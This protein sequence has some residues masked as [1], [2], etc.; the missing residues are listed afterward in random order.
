MLYFQV[1]H[2]RYLKMS[3]SRTLGI[4]SWSR[5]DPRQLLYSIPEIQTWSPH[6][7]K[8]PF[9]IRTRRLDIKRLERKPQED[10][11]V[12]HVILS[13]AIKD[14]QLKLTQLERSYY[15]PGKTAHDELKKWA[16][17][18]KS[19]MKAAGVSN[20]VAAAKVEE[21]V[22]QGLDPK[23]KFRVDVYDLNRVKE[24]YT[25]CRGNNPVKFTDILIELKAILKY[26][27]KYCLSFYDPASLIPLE[28]AQHYE[29]KRSEWIQG[30]REILKTIDILPHK[31]KTS[32]LW[33]SEF[34]SYG[35]ELARQG[36]CSSAPFLVIFPECC[37]IIRNTCT[38]MAS[39]VNA[40]S[41]YA[42]FISNDITDLEQKK[43]EDLRSMQNFQQKYHQLV[44]KLRQTQTECDKL[45]AE[46]DKLKERE[47][48]MIVEE[49]LLNS[50]S[51][52]MQ[53]EIERKEYHREDL[54]RNAAEMHPDIL[55]ERYSQLAEALRDIKRD[56]PFVQRKLFNVRYK[57]SW[58]EEK[59]EQLRLDNRRLAQLRKEMEQTDQTREEKELECDITCKVSRPI[60]LNQ[61][62]ER[63]S[64]VDQFI[65]TN[66]D[67]F[68]MGD[69]ITPVHRQP[70]WLPLVDGNV[71]VITSWWS[72]TVCAGHHD[73]SKKYQ[74][75]SVPVSAVGTSDLPIQD[76]PCS[77]GEDIPWTACASKQ[78]PA[79]WQERRGRWVFL[80][81]C[82]T[83]MKAKSPM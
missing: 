9:F 29:K 49:E 82:F 41:T 73:S 50:Q 46:L 26:L 44:F 37:E 38:A 65:M 76:L 33:L 3:T 48:E 10:L 8:M 60:G 13:G 59:R 43:E 16:P 1:M 36:E 30:I 14:T 5:Q 57:L 70:Y 20:L 75:S 81:Q 17:S 27:E 69:V 4:I 80:L 22:K 66:A 2:N 32:E 23:C 24:C 61:V 12:I 74:F 56:L 62:M 19:V 15:G 42:G 53:M 77:C 51:N 63:L 47:D 72:L 78:C 21:L 6:I 40:D 71:Q 31:F 34:S 83:R 39:W 58:I 64:D 35:I 55:Y 7:Y 25:K 79:A 68:I 67:Q 45:Q 28:T 11:S 18:V 54:F 52:D